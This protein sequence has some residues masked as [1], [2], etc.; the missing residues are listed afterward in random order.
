MDLNGFDKKP[1]SRFFKIQIHNVDLKFY[2]NDEEL[3]QGCYPESPLPAQSWELH[4][5]DLP[6]RRRGCLCP[7]GASSVITI[8][9]VHGVQSRYSVPYSK[10]LSDHLNNVSNLYLYKWPI[11]DILCIF[12]A[13]SFLGKY[14]LYLRYRYPSPLRP[15]IKTWKKTRNCWKI[16]AWTVAVPVPCTSF[17]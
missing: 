3:L 7:Q 1:A 2:Y 11:F 8:S 10:L 12:H 17:L 13:G 5:C 9:F 4:W 14:V 16:C 15:F 6:L